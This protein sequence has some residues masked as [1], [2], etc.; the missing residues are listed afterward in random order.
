MPALVKPV[1]LFGG[2]IAFC[3]CP[4]SAGQVRNFG[5]GKY[6]VNVLPDISRIENPARRCLA[7]GSMFSAIG[8]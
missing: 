3:Q 1:N 4:R 8:A 6:R 2:V 7:C 5:A